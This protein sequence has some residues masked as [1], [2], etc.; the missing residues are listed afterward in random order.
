MV[1]DGT[2]PVDCYPD[3]LSQLKAARHNEHQEWQHD[4]AAFG[5]TAEEEDFPLIAKLFYTIADVERVHGDRFGR[6]AHMVEEG[7]LYQAAQ[8]TQWMCLH[9]GL[10]VDSTVAPAHCPLCRHPQGYFIRREE[11]PFA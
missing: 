9:C 4:Y 3:L 5:K 7:S 8:P 11:N 2:Y 6:Y 10:V 1:V